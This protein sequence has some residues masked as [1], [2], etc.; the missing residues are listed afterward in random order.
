MKSSFSFS[1]AVNRKRK[2]VGLSLVAL[3]DIFT[4]L[5]F[6]L[7]FNLHDEQ[8]INMGKQVIELPSSVQAIDQLKNTHNIDVL[9]IPNLDAVY[10]NDQEIVV[11]SDLIRVTDYIEHACKIKSA[12]DACHTLAIEAPPEMPYPEVDRFVKLGKDL[13]FTDVYLVV[14]KK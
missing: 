9:E 1:S 10:F 14:T 11:D 3:M 8:T 6:F 13:D 12:H 4:V 7:M 5:V 2:V